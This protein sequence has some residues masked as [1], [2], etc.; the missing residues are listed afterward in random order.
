MSNRPAIS[1]LDSPWAA[2]STTLARTTSRYGAERF[3][4]CTWSAR[5]SSG[6]RLMVNGLR[7]G[8]A[9]SFSGGHR[10]TSW[11]IAIRHRSYEMVYLDME[12]DFLDGEQR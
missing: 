11:N 12:G 10:T 9:P 6:D 4:A 3:L 8:I 5:V 7:R 1:S 2:I